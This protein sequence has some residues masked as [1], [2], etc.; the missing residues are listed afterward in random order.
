MLDTATSIK[1][2]VG[3][4]P[5]IIPSGVEAKLEGNVLAIKGPKGKQSVLLD[6]LIQVV[7]SWR[8][9]QSTGKR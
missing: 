4:K 1:S 3:R 9:I 7:I 6:S 8:W 5:V 2:R